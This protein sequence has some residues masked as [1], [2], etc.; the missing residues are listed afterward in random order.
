MSVREVVNYV[1]SKFVYKADPRFLDYWSVMT[2][3]NDQ[4]LGD[5]DDFAL[6]CIWKI[7]DENVLK[8]IFNVMILHKYRF[9][10]SMT[11]DGQKHLVGYAE[12]LYFDNWSREALP[13]EEFLKRTQ[14]KIYVFFPSPAMIFPLALGFLLKLFRKIA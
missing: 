5:C 14:H 9:Y 4:M 7:C 13:K 11:N 3:N 12:G 2:E 1:S 6:T 10:F 8:F